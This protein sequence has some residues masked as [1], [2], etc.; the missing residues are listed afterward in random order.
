MRQ[1]VLE[2]EILPGKSDTK[3]VKYERG[4]CSQAR[5]SLY[6]TFDFNQVWDKPMSSER[7]GRGIRLG[8]QRQTVEEWRHSDASLSGTT[9]P[10]Y[11]GVFRSW[12]E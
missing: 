2:Y 12:G 4:T 1:P 3:P 10:A 11:P 9:K 5:F 8:R 6:E 7:A